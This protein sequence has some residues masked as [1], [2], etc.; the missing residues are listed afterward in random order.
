LLIY[1][2]VF[3]SEML[4][5]VFGNEDTDLTIEGAIPGEFVPVRRTGR[6]EEMGGTVLYL[7]SE[8]GAYCSGMI[9]VIDGGRLGITP[10]A[11]Y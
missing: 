3:P 4:H 11:T 2:L 5:A 6:P 9:H 8:A 10:G 7:A 1:S